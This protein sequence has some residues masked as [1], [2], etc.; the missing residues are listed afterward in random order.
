M[1]SPQRAT[2]ASIAIAAAVMIAAAAVWNVLF[3]MRL[4]TPP[5]PLA[6]NAHYYAWWK[7]IEW[8]TVSIAVLAGGGL[9]AIAV[10][11]LCLRGASASALAIGAVAA[12]FAQLA[13]MGAQHAILAASTSSIDP[14]VLGTIGFV[15][16]GIV[17][18]ISVGAYASMAIGVLGFALREDALPR[19]AWG[20]L[21]GAVLAGGLA[22]LSILSLADPLDVLTPALAL[23][24][25]I[26][27]PAWLLGLAMSM[28]LPEAFA[29]S[30]A[31]AVESR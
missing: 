7:P 1:F 21:T 3:Q 8:Q 10:V 22:V 27:T 9:A 2:L 5:L 13:Q 30:R 19:H 11:G 16:D 26:L 12:M 31:R 17:N 24:G 4:V 23:V 25:A 20:R 29:G 15:A 6:D 28:P 18:G 14:G